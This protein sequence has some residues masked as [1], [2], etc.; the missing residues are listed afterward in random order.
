MAAG[1]ESHPVRLALLGMPVEHSRSPQIHRAALAACGLSGEYEAR[2]V[3]AAGFAAACAELRAGRL[4]GANVTMPHKRAAHDACA[5]LDAEARRAGAVNTLA[6]AEGGLAGWCTDVTAVR[7]ALEEMP[8]GAVLVLGGGGAAAASLVAAAGRPLLLAA[9]RAAAARDLVERLGVAAT[10]VPWGGV[11]R[12]AVV[13]NATPL[14]RGGE[15]LPAG[16]VAAAGG[17][18]DLAYGAVPTPAVM[19][20]RG[21]GI[22]TVDGLTILVDQAAAAFQIWTGREAPRAVM[23]AAAR[24]GES[25]KAG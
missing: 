6:P 18:I 19:A 9:R 5:V 7:S 4:D 2:A 20:A 8:P 12:G 11:V 15:A 1:G 25:L 17:L 23:E 22:P 13:V 14:G 21:A 3:D 24:Y 10:V 16:L